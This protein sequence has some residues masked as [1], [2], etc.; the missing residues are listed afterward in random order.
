MTRIGTAAR[1]L[2]QRGIL[3]LADTVR[4]RREIRFRDR[5]T[6]YC[7]INDGAAGY[8]LLNSIGKLRDLA[9]VVDP[10]DQLVVDIGAHSGLFGRFASERAP[11]ARVVAVEPDPALRGLIERNLATTA[12]YSLVDMAVSDHVGTGTFYRNPQST[13]TSSLI[14]AAVEPFGSE[15][16]IEPFSVTVTT[17]D[18]LWRTELDEQPIDVLKIDVQGAE[19]AVLAGGETAVQHVDKLLIEVSLL[20]PDAAL[21]LPQLENVFGSP[22]VINLVAGGADLLFT[23]DSGPG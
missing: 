3:A 2:Q 11:H 15:A 9:A 16:D 8:H 14:R 23:R 10:T 5:G 4:R 7:I 18:E 21:L 1:L 19:G 22:Q 20:S 13:Q 17:L 6:V 12:S